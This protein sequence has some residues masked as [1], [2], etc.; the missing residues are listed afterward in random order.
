MKKDNKKR[1]EKMFFAVLFYILLAFNTKVTALELNRNFT[2]DAFNTV[3]YNANE[4]DTFKNRTKEEIGEKYNIVETT[5]LTYINYDETTYY[6]TPPSLQSPYERGV[7][8]QDTLNIMTAETNYYRWLMGYSPLKQVLQNDEK[9]QVEALARNFSWGHYLDDTKKPA[10]FPDDLWQEAGPTNF[11]HNILAWNYSPRDAISGWLSEGYSLNTNEFD[12]IGHRV[13]LID[14]TIEDLKFGYSGAIGIGKMYTNNSLNT[15]VPYG[16]FPVPGYM[17]INRLVVHESAWSIALNPDILKVNNASNIVVKVTNLNTN[18]SYDCTT[19]NSKLQYGNPM[20]TVPYLT[21]VQPSTGSMTSYKEKDKFKIEVTG[22]IDVKTSNPA[23]IEYTTEFFDLN[24]YANANVTKIDNNSG[25]EK[26]TIENTSTETLN[27]VAKILPKKV[28]VKTNIG[29]NEE[30]DVLGDWTVDE[31]NNLFVNKIDKSQVSEYTKDPN[32]ILDNNITISYETGSVGRLTVSNTEP[33]EGE[34]GSISLRKYYTNAAEIKIYQISGEKIEKRFTKTTQ[35][36]T[37][38]FDIAS[39]TGKDTGTYLGTYQIYNNLFVIGTEN[40]IVKVKEP[41]K[42]DPTYTIPTNL[43]IDY[44]KKLKDIVLPTG[45]TWQD[46]NLSVG[47]A[48]VN[49]FYV[50]YTPDDT[51]KYNIIENIEVS[52]KVNKIN[53]TYLIPL[54]LQAEYQDK[55][56]SVQLPEGFTWQDEDITLNTSGENTYKATYTPTDI[57]NYNII[58]N[59]DIKVLVNKKVLEKPY[60]ENTNLTYNFSEQQINIINYDKDTMNI[61]GTNKATNANTYSIDVSLKDNTNYIWSD[62]TNNNY[63]LTWNINKIN[64]IIVKIKGNT[65]NTIYDGKEKTV[66]GYTYESNNSSYTDKYFTFIG[67]KTITGTDINTY[68]MGLTSQD[69]ENINN[70]IENVEFIVTDGYLTISDKYSLNISGLSY[71]SK[72]YDGI[73]VTPTGNLKVEDNKVPVEELEIHYFKYINGLYA[74]VDESQTY[75]AGIYKVEYRIP[76]TN[77]LYR[78]SATYEY[79][80]VKKSMN[81]PSIINSNYT[82]NKLEQEVKLNNFDENLMTITGTTKEINANTYEVIISL[83]D[84][85]NYCWNDNTSNDLILDWT[86]N[87][88]SDIKVFINGNIK[89]YIYDGTEKQVDGYSY[90]TSKNIYTESDFEFIGNSTVVGT[91]LGIYNMNLN[92]TDFINKNNNFENVEFIITDGYLEISDKEVLDIEGLIYNDKTYTGLEYIPEGQLEI[93]NNLFDINELEVLYE[94]MGETKYNS[95]I[96]PINVGTYKVTYMIPAD[97]ELYT[98]SKIY[99]FKILKADPVIEIPQNLEAERNTELKDI[100]LPE[101]FAWKQ[102]EVLTPGHNKY[103]AVYTPSDTENYNIIDNIEIDVEVNNYR[104]LEEQLEFFEGLTKKLSF[105]VIATNASIEKLLIANEE[106]DANDYIIENNKVTISEEYLNKLKLGSYVIE[107]VLND[108]EIIKKVFTKSEF[109]EEITNPNTNDNINNSFY[110]L[111]ICLLAT[112]VVSLKIKKY[113]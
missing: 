49:K 91:A 36:Q 87:K 102:N 84:K 11:T 111:F 72:I 26:I 64:K 17:P 44:G 51:T 35:D 50:T 60:I 34:S 107:V 10:D 86:I 95:T 4:W 37:T 59:I 30:V 43:V 57:E 100:L 73:K 16:A 82:Y 1:I 71:V 62:N 2:R 18:E 110:L 90:T 21:F 77:S 81:K 27:A 85:E 47:N 96:P 22:L 13:A 24:N 41:E 55:L 56:S 98:G 78:G 92:K 40:I 32:H 63:T 25:F 8:T 33:N 68:Y 97:N 65:L 88:V 105:S 108:G 99:T 106:L 38:Q 45:F 74:E 14:P 69:F 3:V 75:N 93:T 6:T 5:G 19:A 7:V 20:Y 80:I 94:G 104:I 54:D 28:I 9:L 83:N 113:D 112:I 89:K 67:N 76:D 42:Q 109:I 101:G 61:I 103:I 48:G 12:T 15:T 79:E 66:E 23:K 29:R 46:E 31:V 70:N 58:N 53:P 52:V 39:F